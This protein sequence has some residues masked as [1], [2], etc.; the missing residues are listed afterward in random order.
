MKTTL[1][2]TDGLF[3][4]AKAISERD[5]TTLRAIVEEGLRLVVENRNKGYVPY[6]M[7]DCSF[8][9]P[10]ARNGGL[11]PEAIARGGYRALRE[12]AHDPDFR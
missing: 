5:K 2:I 8:G 6:V 10:G 11:T 3:A 9:E 7:P 12:L 1:D 4:Q